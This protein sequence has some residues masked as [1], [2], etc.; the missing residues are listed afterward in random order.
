MIHLVSNEPLLLPAQ[1][2]EVAA[3]AAVA[4]AAAWA[5]PGQ[6]NLDQPAHSACELLHVEL[7]DSAFA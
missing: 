3:N 6:T 5:W 2:Y 7:H 4:A 1:V